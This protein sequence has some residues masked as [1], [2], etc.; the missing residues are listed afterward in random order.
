MN[1]YRIL[2]PL[3]VS[4]ERGPVALGGQKQRALLGLLLM[5][6]G[7]VVATD[8]LVDQLWGEL[9]PRTATTS[10]Q[11]HV[12][13]LR[14]LLGAET[15]VTRPPGYVLE[16]DAERRRPGAFRAARCA[17][18]VEPSQRCAQRSSVR[19]LRSGAARRLRTWPSRRS[20]RPRSD[21]SWRC[22]SEALEERID[23]DLELG[24][25]IEPR[26]RA[27]SARGR[28]TREGATSRS[29]DARPVPIGTAGRS[30]R[31]LPR[32][33]SG[34]LRAARNRPGP[35]PSSCFTDGYSA[36]S[37]CLTPAAVC[38]HIPSRI[39]TPRCVKA[40]LGRATRARSR[41]RR[42]HF[43]LRASPAWTRS[44][45]ISPTRF[46]YPPPNSRAGPCLRVRRAHEGRRTALRRAARPARPRLRARHG[47]S[48]S[49]GGCQAARRAR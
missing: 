14:K 17:R 42:A 21:G 27:G 49:R 7:E 12:S 30:A 2:G 34:A 3:E 47:A 19:R 20:R 31:R 5:R 11:N 24:R 39:T 35:R 1:E 40:L 29:A 32:G 13:Q 15:I 48:F 25:G 36:R 26:P 41:H 43:E 4:G 22:D 45:P 18:P 33:T 38:A 9:P 37:R 44:P 46:G 28:V 23:A 16:V 8:R 6:A 10:L